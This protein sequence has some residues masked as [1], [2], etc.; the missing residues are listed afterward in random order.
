MDSNLWIAKMKISQH[1][2]DYIGTVV[3]EMIFK[4]ILLKI[5]P[6]YIVLA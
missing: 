2:W 3:S 4:S 1:G 5:I 6:S